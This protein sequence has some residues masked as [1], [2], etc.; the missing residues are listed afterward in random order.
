[1]KYSII[2][3]SFMLSLLINSCGVYNFTGAKPVDAKTFQVNYFQNNSELIEPGIERTFT[4]RLQ[5]IIQNQTNLSLTNYNGD[6]LYEGE[7]VEYRITPMQATANQTA[8][9]SRLT[10]S[11]N[12]RFKNKNNRARR[13][14]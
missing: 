6:L 14:S 3:L 9:E 5:E 8:A 13:K 4:I 2:V 10:I 1:M 11:V 12:V 7:I